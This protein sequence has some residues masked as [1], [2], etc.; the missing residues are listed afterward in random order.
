MFVAARDVCVRDTGTVKGRG[1]FALRA[2][3]PDELVE[4]CAVVLLPTPFSD[5]P[6]ELRTLVFNW[7]FLTK[8]PGMHALALGHGSLYNHDNPSNL[9]YTADAAAQLLSFVS[10][11]RIEAGEELT[12]NYNAHGGGSTWNDN[13]WFERMKVQPIEST[14]AARVPR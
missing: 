11:R 5:L 13:A 9:R 1:V 6:E 2:F 12:I 3:E 10:A 4:Q 8:G 7:G 14:D